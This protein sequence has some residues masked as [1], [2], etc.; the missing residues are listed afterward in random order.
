MGMCNGEC[1]EYMS[2]AVVTTRPTDRSAG[3]DDDKA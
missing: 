1:N 3:T 2:E